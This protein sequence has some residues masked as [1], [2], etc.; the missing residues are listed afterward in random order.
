MGFILNSLTWRKNMA[1][2]LK[3]KTHRYKKKTLTQEGKAM[4]PSCSVTAFSLA[5]ALHQVLQDIR[6]VILFQYLRVFLIKRQ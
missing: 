3:Q 4:A 6:K 5:L 1:A 2:F